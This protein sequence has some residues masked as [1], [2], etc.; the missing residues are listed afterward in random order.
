MGAPLFTVVDPRSMRLEGSVP[1]AD[2]GALRIGAPVRF[3]VSGYPGRTFDG[4]IQRINP[5]AD[6]VT[7]QVPVVVSIPNDGG[8]LVALAM[9]AYYSGVVFILGAEFAAALMTKGRRA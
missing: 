6:P 4:T 9:F 1:A 7:R 3:T 5:A 2:L 8:V